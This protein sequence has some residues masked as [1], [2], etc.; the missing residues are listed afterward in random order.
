M[1][2][3][4]FWLTYH[5]WLC[6]GDDSKR[7]TAPDWDQRM[8]GGFQVYSLGYPQ[9][10][11]RVTFKN[12]QRLKEDV[13]LPRKRPSRSKNNLDIMMVLWQNVLSSINPMIMWRNQSNGPAVEQSG[14]KAHRT[15]RSGSFRDCT[16]CWHEDS[17][18]SA[19]H[20]LPYSISG[21]LCW[22]AMK[23]WAGASQLLFYRRTSLATSWE[24]ELQTQFDVDSWSGYVWRGL[25]ENGTCMMTRSP[26]GEKCAICWR[27]Y[28]TWSQ[29]WLHL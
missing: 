1:G 14:L 29:M 26:G 16:R 19:G 18:V 10:H 11:R 5:L 3:E 8:S 7:R 4:L 25:H 6:P 13:P 23:R 12:P 2:S 17:A 15:P 24:W 20:G 9:Y 28:A 21:L 22:K 27:L